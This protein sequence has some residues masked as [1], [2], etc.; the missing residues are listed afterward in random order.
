MKIV[1]EDYVQHLSGYNYK[2]LYDPQLLHDRGFSYH[3]RIFVEFQLLYRWHALVPDELDI[4]NRSYSIRNL[5]FNPKPVVNAGMAE[6]VDKATKQFAGK[7]GL[8][9]TRLIQTVIIVFSTAQ[10]VPW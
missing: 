6:W 10:M 8:H 3:N 1:I 2:L 4:G 9:S 7:V 5:I